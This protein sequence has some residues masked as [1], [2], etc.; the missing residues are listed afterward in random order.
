MY[1]RSNGKRLEKWNWEGKEANHVCG[2]NAQGD[3]V[4]HTSELPSWRNSQKLKYLCLCNQRSLIKVFPHRDVN[5]KTH[6]ALPLNRPSRLWQSEG[7]P[8]TKRCRCW[9]LGVKSHQE[10]IKWVWRDI[11][12]APTASSTE[13]LFLHLIIKIISRAVVRIKHSDMCIAL[14]LGMDTQQ[15]SI[16]DG[17][18]LQHSVARMGRSTV[19]D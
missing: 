10:N 12:G 18:Y 19:T 1:A 9:L 17:N 2:I 15:H 6:S 13:N 16:G 7:S 8:P 14:S 4:G 5:S 11:S 3:S